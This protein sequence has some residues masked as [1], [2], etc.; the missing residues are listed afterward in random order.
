[1]TTQEHLEKIVTKC[2]ELLAIAEKRTP[3]KWESGPTSQPTQGLLVR[4]CDRY[5]KWRASTQMPIEDAAFIAAC[6]G[7]AEAGWRS[8]IAAIEGLLLIMADDKVAAKQLS[9]HFGVDDS[10]PPEYTPSKTLDA[11]IAAW[12]EELL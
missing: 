5:A 12:P 9:N 8:T 2:R 1:M 6:A 11:I 3:G 10:L 7:A 4:G